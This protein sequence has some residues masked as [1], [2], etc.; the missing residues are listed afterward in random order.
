MARRHKL[1]VDAGDQNPFAMSTGDMMSGLMFVFLLFII[2]LAWQIAKQDN[3]KNQKISKYQDTRDEIFKELRFTFEDSL[4]VWGAELDSSTLTIRFNEIALDGTPVLFAPGDSLLPPRY[5]SMMKY[6]FPKYLEILGSEKYRD[7]IEEIRIEGHTDSTPC[8]SL[9]NTIERNYLYNMNLSQAR[10]RNVLRYGLSETAVAA[11]PKLLEF[12][13]ANIIATGLSFSQ[14][15]PTQ[16]KSRRVEIRVRTKAQEQ[17]E[18]IIKSLK[19]DS[20]DD[21]NP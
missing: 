17:L 5:K 4:R 20:S 21:E 16:D 2:T 8:Y 19:E 9:C 11:S 6:F 3:D 15:R 13:R 7:H 10:S 12:A 18:K 1:K 14:P